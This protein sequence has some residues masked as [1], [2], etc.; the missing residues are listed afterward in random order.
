MRDGSGRRSG[1]DGAEHR[2]RLTSETISQIEHWWRH[3]HTY[4]TTWS[5]IDTVRYENRV[6]KA[7]DI[8]ACTTVVRARI[9]CTTILHTGGNA[10]YNGITPA[11]FHRRLKTHIGPTAFTNESFS[12]HWLWSFIYRT[13]FTD[14]WLFK[15]CRI[16]LLIVSRFSN[17]Y[18][19]FSSAGRANSIFGRKLSICLS[20]CVHQATQITTRYT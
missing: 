18:R 6:R 17:I 14:L 10:C 3:G 20:V 7:G 13:D 16:F 5:E 11:L 1:K 9:L 19:H 8:R 15:F 4:D 2:T 12:P